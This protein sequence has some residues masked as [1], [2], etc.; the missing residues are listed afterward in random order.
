M[1]PMPS[2]KRVEIC[3]SVMYV[4]TDMGK[5]E[6]GMKWPGWEFKLGIVLVLF[7]IAVYWIK[8]F[9]LGDPQ[10]TYFYVFNA[11]GF[12]PL[13]VLLVTLILNQLLIMRSRKEK[14]EKMN[15][16][17]GTFFSEAGTK[18]LVCFSDNDPN[19]EKIRSHLIVSNGWSDEE[20]NRVHKVLRRYTYTVDTKNID[21]VSLREFL[22]Q[23]RSFLVRLLENPVLLE[24]AAFTDLLR[25]VFHLTE[26]LESRPDFNELPETDYS[27]LAGDIQ[28]AYN[29]L[30]SQWLDYM[31]Y[32][33]KDYPY[34]FSLAMRKNPFDET[35]SP[36]V[37]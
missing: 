16:V 25:A 6:C 1:Y 8:F 2:S 9:V 28:R 20:W 27:H 26:E 19:L 7:S 4:Q 35:A 24:H 14:M 34:L 5:G 10:N 31:R 23:Q 21:F 30:A 29:L 13:N 33:K 17:I 32:L 3:D 12:L 36:I 37:R 22:K 15:M 11:L 18:L